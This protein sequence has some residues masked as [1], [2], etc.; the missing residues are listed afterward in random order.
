MEFRTAQAARVIEVPR[1]VM[2]T[3][4]AHIPEMSDIIITVLAARRRQQLERGDRSLVLIGEEVNRDVRRIAEFAG[5]NRL[6]CTS[7]AIGSDERI[8][9]RPAATHR[10]I[11]R[12]SSSAKGSSSPIRRPRRSHG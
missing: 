8:R 3:F 10:Q 2:L 9:S 6:P 4:M 7:H 11:N 5:R 12:W 1:A